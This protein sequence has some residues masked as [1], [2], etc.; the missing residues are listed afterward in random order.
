MPS[1]NEICLMEAVELAGRVREGELSPVEVVDAVLE[2][3]EALEPRLHAFCTPTPELA[4]EEAKR[5]EEKI[6]SDEEAGPLAGVP[7]GIKDLHAAK[8][9]RMTMGSRAYEDFVPDEDDVAV[10]RLK[11]AGAIVLGKTNVPEFGYSG[12]SD[13]PIFESTTNPWD[14][15]LT[16]GGSSAGSAAAVATG[17]GA[18]RPRERRRRLGTH[19]RELLRPLR[20]EGFDGPGAAVPG[21]PRRE[22]SWHVKLGILGAHRPPEPHGARRRPHALGDGRPRR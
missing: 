11:G 9:I 5:M 18:D 20:D 22:P 7:V 8:G 21:L 13:N 4:R 10:E 1:N 19:P 6:A 14:T 12:A 17:M 15:N 3:M 16:S 2:R